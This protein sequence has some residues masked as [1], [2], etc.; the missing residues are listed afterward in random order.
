MTCTCPKCKTDIEFDVVSILAEGHLQK[1]TACQ[2]NVEVRKESFAKRALYKSP[3]I[4]CAE[5]G[6]NPGPS[7]YC[8]SCHAI[9]PDILTVA[10]ASSAKRQLD[11]IF[12]S[13]KKLNY[14]FKPQSSH[15][16]YTLDD[17]AAA[18]AAGKK[19][20]TSIKLPGTTAQLA[21][22]LVLLLGVFI[23]GGYFWYQDKI[24]TEY[25]RNYVKVLYGVKGARDLN[26]TL[27]TSLVA[28]WKSGGVSALSA[29]ELKVAASS[30]KDVAAMVGRLG[31]VPKQFTASND[32]LKKLLDSYEKLYT[33]TTSHPISADIYADNVK[34]MD[35]EFVKSARELKASMPE[36]IA[37]LFNASKAKYKPL[38]DF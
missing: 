19:A 22:T 2:A 36:K 29:N 10:T 7:I 27:S 23:A 28:N 30:H 9:Y 16:S 3:E 17:L 26:I 18:P 32:A 21:I 6:N 4:Y 33:T 24:A 20:K 15:K 1:C 25:S 13:L 8:Q 14:K 31:K 38:Q 12:A 5:C 37:D 35:G 11:K 34:K